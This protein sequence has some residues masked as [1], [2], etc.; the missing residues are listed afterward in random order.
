[1]SLSIA[2]PTSDWPRWRS[3]CLCE[4]T[5]RGERAFT[6]PNGEARTSLEDGDEVI[7]RAE[8]DSVVSIGFGEYR[9]ARAGAGLAHD[10]CDLTGAPTE[11]APTTPGRNT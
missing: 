10:E 7:F 3:A 4:V 1:M 5:G 2:A 6:L 11:R 8:R 9:A